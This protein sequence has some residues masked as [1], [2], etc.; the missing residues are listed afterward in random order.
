[1]ALGGTGERHKTIKGIF[2]DPELK[3]KLDQINKNLIALYNKS[4]S[5]WRAFFR[6]VASGIGSIVGVAIALAIAGWVLNS[7]GVIPAFREQTR[8]W[9]QT[10]EEI[11]QLK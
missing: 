11:R 4:E 10:L 3:A 5:L 6:G 1:M 8:Q 7:I 9:Q 2:M